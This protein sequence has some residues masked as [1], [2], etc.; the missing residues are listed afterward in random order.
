MQALARTVVVRQIIGN[1]RYIERPE[2]RLKLF[3]PSAI[4]AIAASDRERT[5]VDPEGIAP[6]DR[7]G[8]LDR[9]ENRNSI[10]RVGPGMKRHLVDALWLSGPQQ[11]HATIGHQRGV[12]TK[13][14]VH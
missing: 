10:F 13:N 5:L 14:S 12:V 4:G 8:R 7:P 9:S 6:L 3:D 11:Y 2:N 1:H